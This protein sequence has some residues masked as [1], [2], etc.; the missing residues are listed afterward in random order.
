MIIGRG[1]HVSSAVG[2]KRLEILASNVLTQYTEASRAE[3]SAI[4]TS[5]IRKIYQAGGEFIQIIDAQK[6][7]WCY[8][9]ENAIR[10]KVGSILRNLLHDQYR[11]SI[12]SKVKARRQQAAKRKSDTQPERVGSAYD[13]L[14]Q[15][16]EDGHSLQG[17]LMQEQLD[18]STIPPR[19]ATRAHRPSTGMDDDI[20]PL[21]LSHSNA[22]AF[23]P[24]LTTEEE[25]TLDPVLSSL[26]S[27]SPGH[28]NQAE[29]SSSVDQRPSSPTSMLPESRTLDNDIL[30]LS[31]NQ[32]NK[33]SSSFD[34][35]GSGMTNTNNNSD[36]KSNAI[37]RG[38]FDSQN[39]PP[40]KV[41][42]RVAT[43][44]RSSIGSNNLFMPFPEVERS[45][46]HDSNDSNSQDGDGKD[47]VIGN[48]AAKLP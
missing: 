28:V 2:N 36:D 39:H 42:E 27:G 16:E 17:Q 43:V 34:T 13:E 40:D 24:T 46:N 29:G 31:P 30:T 18:S 7:H 47:D 38:M 35:V 5:L 32:S 3:K 41:D 12:K 11:S 25:I 14:Q 45:S 20:L 15:S 44:S 37:N 8:A 19:T 9:R 26:L 6:G 4:V 48:D 33:G 23:Q 22:A 10:D 1:R 21:V